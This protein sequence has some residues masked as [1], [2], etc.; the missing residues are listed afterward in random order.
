MDIHSTKPRYVQQLFW[1]NLAICCSNDQI[2]IHLPDFFNGSCISEPLR[3]EEGDIHLCCCSCNGRRC[4]HAFSP[5]RLV[6]LAD[7]HGDPM[8]L[9]QC[10]EHRHRKIGCTHEND[11]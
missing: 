5:H 10:P 11:G 3:L 6:R 1:K 2:G 8:I 7:D 4:Q 9:L